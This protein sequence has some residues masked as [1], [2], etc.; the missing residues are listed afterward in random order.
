MKFIKDIHILK[1]FYSSYDIRFQIF[2]F[3]IQQDVKK[4]DI[5][6]IPF[7][8][9]DEEALSWAGGA[10]NKSKSICSEEDLFAMK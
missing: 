2:I 4:L 6:K 8:D 9:N 1:T 10:P 3:D 7:I 5:E